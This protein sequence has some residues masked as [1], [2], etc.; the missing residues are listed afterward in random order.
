MLHIKDNF[1]SG[2]PISQVPA[3]WFNAVASFINNLVGGYAIKLTKNAS[4]ASVI[5]VDPDVL[6]AENLGEEEKRSLFKSVD[7]EPIDE[8]AQELDKSWGSTMGSGASFQVV[9]RVVSI[10]G[11]AYRFYLRDM[12]LDST[13]RVRS[14]SK[15]KGY[16]EVASM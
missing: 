2:A 9:S 15:E 11:I 6:N 7:M 12:E 14:I 13:G 1:K 5:S 10:G 16:F 8:S 3:S 4:G